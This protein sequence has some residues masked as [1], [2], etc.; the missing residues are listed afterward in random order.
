MVPF[1]FQINTNGLP[2]CLLQS[3]ILL[4]E[5]DAVLFQSDSNVGGISTVLN[6]DLNQT[7]QRILSATLSDE[8]FIPFSLFLGD[9]PINQAQHYKYLGVLIDANLNFKQ[10][11]QELETI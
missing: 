6:K 5:D 4:Y 7:Q 11:F 10:D 1:C 8:P 2:K 9:K 3:K